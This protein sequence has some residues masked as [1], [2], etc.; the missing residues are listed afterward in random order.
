MAVSSKQ[1]ISTSTVFKSIGV[2]THLEYAGY[3]YQNHAATISAIKYLG[4]KNLRDSP[5]SSKSVG[6][7]GIWQKVADA[8][9]A[10]FDAYLNRGSTASDIS[11]LAN[12][13][14]LAAQGILNYIEG[15]NE[16]DLAG[17]Y[18]N[19]ISW[20]KGFQ[21]TVYDTAHAAGLPV[22]NMSFGAGWTWLNDWKGNYD[23]VGDL[24]RVADYANAHTYPNVNQ[25]TDES[26]ERLN[27]LAKIA[28]KS[29]P[30]ITTEIGW[31]GT[32]YSGASI[33]RHV[34]EAVFDGIENH[35]VKTYF[36]SLY[37]DVSGKFG[38]MNANGTPRPAG[39]ALHNLTTLLADSGSRH[40]SLSYGLTGTTAND[41]QLLMQKANGAFQ[42]ALWNEKEGAHT[43]KLSLGKTASSV[44]IFQP[45]TGTAPIKTYSNTSSVNITL[46]AAPIIVEIVSAGT[47]PTAPPVSV[48]TKPP[49]SAPTPPTKPAPPSTTGK[50]IYGDSNDDIHV[51]GGVNDIYLLG[52]DGSIKADA[53][54]NTMHTSGVRNVLSGGKGNDTIQ[55]FGAGKNVL[56]GG[57]G[58]DNIRFAGSG[59]VVFVGNGND[60]I[61]DSG[62]ANRI[63]FD[64]AGAGLT[65]V[66][67]YVLK[68]GDTLDFSRT[69]AATGWDE[70]ASTLS[71][72]LKVAMQGSNA[73]LS[74]NP[75]GVSGGKTQAFAVLHD[76]GKVSLSGLLAHS[77]VA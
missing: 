55:A 30:I 31:K 36:Y 76:T 6:P 19:S 65:H 47:I 50:T 64:K 34:V 15:V 13:K 11:G 25:R 1:A 38:L 27:G 63:V 9:G 22:I 2:N 32:D 45:T 69:L 23:K 53:G 20:S 56:N 18:G 4:V 77:L 75:T 59:N 48:P 67:G 29:R 70:K 57:A 54:T 33:A 62:R 61:S 21:K 16:S 41:H 8:T 5:N 40:D 28:A 17:M 12:A 24:S 49:V 74:V 35:N 10:K 60:T 44:K 72:Y 46:P 66:K 43:I 37:D 14:K 68:N 3:G 7:N 26:M 73:V 39:T 42:L 52:N 51:K 58:N 71:R